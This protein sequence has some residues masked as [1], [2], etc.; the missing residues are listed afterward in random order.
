M[1]TKGRKHPLRGRADECAALRKLLSSVDASASQ[2][3]VLR[4]EAGVG[5]TALLRFLRDQAAGF[6]VTRIAGVESDMELAFAG[7]QQLCA[8]LL[9]HIDEL[10]EPQRAAL[11]VA[12]GLGAGP[13][14]DRFLVGLAVLSLI[15]AAADDQPLLCVI[16]DAQWLDQV[17]LQTLAFIARRLLAEPIGFVFAARDYGAH[18]LAGLPE[19]VIEGLSDSHA[20]ELLDSVVLGRIDEHV[21]DRIVAETRG[22]PLAL[23]EVPR[24][25]SAAE[26]AGGFGDIAAHRSTGHIEDNFVRTIESL[27]GETQRLLLAAAAEPVGDAALFI[28]AA[29]ELGIPVKALTPAEAAGL[30]E[31]GPRVR[32][33]HPLVRSAVY[34]SAELGARRAVHRALAAA[35]DATQDPDRRAWHAANAAAGPDDA[36]AAELE[37]SANRAQSRGGIAAA[38]AFLERAAVLSAN[39]ALRGS[40]AIAAA[41]AKRDAADPG[42]AYELLAIAELC[43]LSDLQRAQ[44]ARLRAQME[45]TRSRV[46]EPGAP[47]V[48]EAATLLFDAARR[49]ENLDDELARETYLEALAAGMFAGRLGASGA[50]TVAAEAA[51]AAL[52][53]LSEI[54][55]PIDF[56][57]AGMAYRLTGRIKECAAPLRT[58]VEFWCT[59]A[60]R[61]DGQSLRWITLAFPVVQESAT[62][63]LWDDALM[64]QLA[65]VMVRYARETGALAILPPALAYRAGVHILAGEFSLAATLLEEAE[66]IS[67]AIDDK[68]IRYH[69]LHLAAWQGVAADAAGLLEAAAE[70]AAR[71]GEGRLLGV[72]NGIGA[73]LY[74]GLGRYEEAFSAVS[75]T[76]EYDDL[77]F[78][79]WCLFELTEAAVHN[80][81][82]DAAA[83]AVRRL[84]ETAGGSGTDWGLG[85]LASAQA[86]LADNDEADA[87]FNEAIERLQSTNVVV[88]LARTHLRYGE[89]LRRVNRRPDARRQLTEAFELFTRMGAEGFA[90]RT[91]RELAA[92]GEKVRKQPV[93]SGD[94]MTAQEA[95][96]ARLAADGLTNQEIGAQLFISTHTVEWHLRKVFVKLNISSRRQ[97]RTIE[98]AD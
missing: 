20:R 12:F 59:H 40:R 97:L 98:W 41:Q 13:P 75:E 45:F 15:A 27:P 37:A 87:L 72:A 67:A 5:K 65:D 94:R 52:G 39:P 86:M 35:T 91:R 66:A 6:R 28:R 96:I 68:P 70:V 19:L 10:P 53:R 29:G 88:H 93:T 84:E 57:L 8:P 73:I 26:L 11:T 74:N 60:Q 18:A 54:S 38:A 31:F 80:G 9:D 21:R 58:A 79:G 2:V 3:L 95:Q 82:P 30:I 62:G 47:Q 36:V 49:L 56:L 23:L 17:S 46:G 1:D 83:Q 48:G 50:L 64:E 89:W 78:G 92:S 34:R 33:H 25:V 90:E 14:P 4:G 81:E 85:A 43:P 16:D 44:V 24:N 32:F 42:A 77:G 55:R 71:K 61:G 69:R 76:C 7:L 51:Q 63:E 22:V